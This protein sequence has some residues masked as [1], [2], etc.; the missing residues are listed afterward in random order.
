MVE[1]FT[2]GGGEYIVNVLNAVA[3]WTG[4][5][6]YKSLIQV[7]LVMGFALAVIVVAFN[8]DWRAWL[9]WF[10]GAT[11]IY[12]CLMVPRMDVQVTDRVNPSKFTI[13]RW[14][15]RHQYWHRSDSVTA[16]SIESVVM[17]RAVSEH[18]L[19]DL[20]EF[21]QRDTKEF[22]AEHGIPYR[23]SY[24]LH[25]APGAGKTSTIQAVAGKYGRNVC[26]LSPGHPEMDDEGLKRA[27]EQVPSKSLIV[28]EDIDALFDEKRKKKKEDKSG[29]TFSG[30]LNALDGVGSSSGQLF[31]LTTNH[32]ERLDPALIRNGRV[33]V[34]VEFTDATDEQ[35]RGLFA[36]F[37]RQATYEQ[38]V[39]FQ[40]SLREK[41]GERTVS[42]A[43]LQSFFIVLRKKSA[44]EA[45]ANVGLI[46]DEMDSRA[47]TKD[48]EASEETTKTE[49]K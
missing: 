5:G 27:M 7:A 34:H 12:M 30:L 14:H 6:G 41:L 10:L 19:E 8:Q 24:L 36:Q 39:A 21:L 29:I 48:A 37:Y 32:R 15:A 47:A 13:W 4:A 31:F 33:D 22:Y 46:L 26:Y 2:T 25:G 40:E 28:L 9:N 20:D 23:R 1:I 43:A 16:R 38:A 35:I 49:N 45:I 3:A 17:P 11:L 42:M 44:A 18:L